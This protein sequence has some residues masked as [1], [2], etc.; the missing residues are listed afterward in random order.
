MAKLILKQP[1]S[2]RSNELG[3][4]EPQRSAKGQGSRIQNMRHLLPRV[5]GRSKFSSDPVAVMLQQ[6]A[7]SVRRHFLDSPAALDDVLQ[8]LRTN[9]DAPHSAVHDEAHDCTLEDFVRCAVQCDAC[10][11][12]SAAQRLCCAPGAVGGLAIA[13]RATAAQQAAA[14]TTDQL[15]VCYGPD[16]ALCPPEAAAAAPLLRWA[17]GG[18]GGSRCA[19]TCLSSDSLLTRQD[20]MHTVVQLVDTQPASQHG[21][22]VRCLAGVAASCFVGGSLDPPGGDAPLHPPS[23]SAL[24]H[25]LELV[26]G[27]RSCGTVSLTI[28]TGLVNRETLQQRVAGRSRRGSVPEAATRQPVTISFASDAVWLPQWAGAQEC[29]PLGGMLGGCPLLRTVYR[30]AVAAAAMLSNSKG[31]GSPGAR[32]SGQGVSAGGG[33]GGDDLPSG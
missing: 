26:H 32:A 30:G 15:P 13:T 24:E 20:S 33:G 18:E 3:A 23:R 6:P 21:G 14:L 19:H 11:A 7:A 10:A 27:G 12:V 17:L 22:S 1:H 2:Q 8:Q 16:L 4:E 9:N 5:D 29:C 31:P 25:V 28:A